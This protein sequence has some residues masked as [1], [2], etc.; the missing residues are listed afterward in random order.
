M[1]GTTKQPAYSPTI[2]NRSPLP[3]KAQGGLVRVVLH[4][5]HQIGRLSV[6][7]GGLPARQHNEDSL[8]CCSS[9]CSSASTG[10]LLS[11]INHIDLIF[12]TKITTKI[13]QDHHQ[14]QFQHPFNQ[15]TYVSGSLAGGWKMRTWPPSGW[16]FP[17]C[18]VLATH[19]CLQLNAK[20]PSI[21]YF[22]DQ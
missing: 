11:C 17:R 7:R 10:G 15:S 2:T 14:C 3:V 13:C 19:Y 18:Y 6:R 4:L 12:T 8:L 1:M 9:G 5:F 22:D 16:R 21:L 20:K